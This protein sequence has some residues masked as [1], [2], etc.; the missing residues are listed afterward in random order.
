M[1]TRESLRA[2][3]ACY[4]D[5]KIEAIVPTEGLTP[6]QVAALGAVPADD[7]HWA[8]M[9]ASGASERVLREH[10][11]WCA[12]Q[13]LALIAEPDPR[14]VAAVDV[15]ERYARGEATGEE[16]S[17]ACAASAAG[18]AA[19]AYAWAAQLLDLAARIEAEGGSR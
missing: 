19:S 11:C 9:Y 1:I 16:L 6:S 13:A 10:A 17:A 4:S 15:A 8:L 2:A 3:G 7:R 14:S 18:A 5:D 12:R